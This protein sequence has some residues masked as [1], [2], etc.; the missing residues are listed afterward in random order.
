MSLTTP[1][2]RPRQRAPSKK[3]LETRRRILDAA[4]LAFA[5]GGYEGTALRDIAAAAGVPVALVSFHGG[6]KEELYFTVVERRA[7]E[8]SALRLA[9]LDDLG[10]RGRVTLAGVLGCFIRPY[11]ERAAN[12]GPQWLAYARL[13]AQV[14]ADESWRNISERCFDPT[15]GRFVGELAAFFPGAARREIAA[16]FVFAVS[17]ML[18]LATSAWRIDALGDGAPEPDARSLEDWAGFSSPMPGAGS[19]RRSARGR[20]DRRRAGPDRTASSRQAAS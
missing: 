2:A 5:R 17:A 18:A 9:A 12:G 13:V 8:L 3:S 4:E 14:S 15:A 11:L 20:D 1:A 7:D 6:A 16:G 10:S 19:R